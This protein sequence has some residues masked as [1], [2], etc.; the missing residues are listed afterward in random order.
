[1]KYKIMEYDDVLKLYEADLDLRVNDYH[2]KREELIG[3]NGSIVDFANGHEY[4]GIHRTSEGWVYRE[5]APGA[6]KMYLAGEFNGWN[7]RKHPM[8]R[9]ENGVFEIKL[10]KDTLWNGCKVLAI[11]EH[12]GQELERIPLYARRVVQDPTTYLWSAEVYDPETP[13]HG[14]IRI[15]TVN[16]RRIFMSVMLVWLRRREKLVLILNLQI[17][18]FRAYKILDIILFRLWLLWSILTTVPLVIRSAAFFAPAS[19]SG[20]PED[21]KYLVNKAHSMV[22]VC[23]LMLYILMRQRIHVRESTSSMEQITSSS[24]V[25]QEAIIRLGIPDCL[26]ME[27]MKLFISC[28][29][30]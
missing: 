12:D 25:A 9:L 28:F 19:R 5:W 23:C 11:V 10:S 30:I 3:A 6:S 8:E 15:S 24:T 14:R 18:Y 7:H 26:I 13:L 1:M 17:R 29:Q 27:R 16:F 4:F 2:K 20:M 21:L 22:F